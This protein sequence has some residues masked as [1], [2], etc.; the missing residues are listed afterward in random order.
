MDRYTNGVSD[1]P[2]PFQQVNAQVIQPPK[3]VAASSSLRTHNLPTKQRAPRSQK[4]AGVEKT[5]RTA[6]IE[7]PIL[8]RFRFN[9]PPPEGVASRLFLQKLLS[10]EADMIEALKM[11][12]SVWQNQRV[13]WSKG[14]LVAVE[15]STVGSKPPAE[16]PR[17]RNT[18]LAPQRRSRPKCHPCKEEREVWPSR[19]NWWRWSSGRLGPCLQ[20][21]HLHASLELL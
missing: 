19:R 6:W 3:N 7:H 15:V 1:S 8:P 18:T 2:V 20:K 21:C 11:V 9:D 17:L 13:E 12:S 10:Y 14:V 5:F 4:R 16:C